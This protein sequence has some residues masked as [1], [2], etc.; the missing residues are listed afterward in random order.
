M[1]KPVNDLQCKLVVWL[2][3]DKDIGIVMSVSYN[4]LTL[5]KNWIF[6]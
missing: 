5:Y 1:Q 3:H 2:L 6:S 4:D